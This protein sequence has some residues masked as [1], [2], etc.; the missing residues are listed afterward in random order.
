MV[1][2]FKGDGLMTE[3]EEIKQAIL[4][5][6]RYE[7]KLVWDIEMKQQ[8]LD[9]LRKNKIELATIIADGN[10]ELLQMIIEK[11]KENV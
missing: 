11:L 1:S 6:H 9:E 5:L 7:K 8:E 10:V 4:D 3:F 2:Y